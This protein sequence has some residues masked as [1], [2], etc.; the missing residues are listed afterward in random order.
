MLKAEIR[1]A[2]TGGGAGSIANLRFQDLKEGPAKQDLG[3]AAA[4]ALPGQTPTSVR[5]KGGKLRQMAVNPKCDRG[6]RGVRGKGQWPAIMV[7]YKLLHINRLLCNQGFGER[8]TPKF[9]ISPVS[10]IIPPCTDHNHSS[11]VAPL[12]A[13]GGAVAMALPIRKE[14]VETAKS[15]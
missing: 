14:A 6:G 3:G 13:G 4:T 2:G 11:A 9:L 8:K 12:P 7:R 15:A 1:K 10:P 5:A